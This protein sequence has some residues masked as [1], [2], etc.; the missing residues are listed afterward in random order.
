MDGRVMSVEDAKGVD[1]HPNGTRYW[2]PLATEKL[3]VERVSELPS[4]L[5]QDGLHVAYDQSRE[6]LYLTE[7]VDE[8]L[9][10]S[11]LLGLGSQL[12]LR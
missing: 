9:E 8:D 1:D 4:H 3:S 12:E 2:T 7:Q 11:A 6:I 10:R 5:A